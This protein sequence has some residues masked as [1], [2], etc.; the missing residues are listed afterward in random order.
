VCVTLPV[1]LFCI[2]KLRDRISRPAAVGCVTFALRITSCCQ[3]MKPCMGPK[4]A[5]GLGA[6]AA[7]LLNEQIPELFSGPLVLHDGWHPA[8]A[9]ADKTFAG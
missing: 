3:C 9:P 4:Q 8:L 2:G 1:N 7:R 5:T 6:V